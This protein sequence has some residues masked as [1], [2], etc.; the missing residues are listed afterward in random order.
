[1]TGFT[2]R[3][4][5]ELKEDIA[6]VGRRLYERKL[7]VSTDGN[8]SIRIS[9][10][11]ILITASGVCKGYL[12]VDQI[13]KV[14]MS[15][16][17]LSGPKPARDIR[18]HLAAYEIREH[19]RAVVH[20]HPPITTGFAISG[21]RFDRMTLPE[22]MFSIGTVGVTEYATPTTAEVPVVVSKTLLED[23]ECHALI[24]ANHGA[25]TLGSD[26]YDAYYKMETLEMFLTA[27]LVAR[28]LGNENVLTDEQAAA[29]RA[30]VTGL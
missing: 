7:N 28:A 15:G 27:T 22:I 9:E 26:I 13:T 6:E 5:S 10:N 18:M 24:L 30:L 17:V 19:V 21:A 1:M 25:L 3:S 2:S 4:E 14:D 23:P 12:T 20:C 16:N 29:V 11:E 8:M